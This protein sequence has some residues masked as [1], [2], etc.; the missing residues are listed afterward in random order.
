[1]I[2]DDKE[3]TIDVIVDA[4]LEEH[5]SPDAPYT[6]LISWQDRLMAPSIVDISQAVAEAKE[7]KERIDNI[8]LE[9]CFESGP[10]EAR[11][12]ILEACFESGPS[13][14]PTCG[15]GGSFAPNTGE[16]GEPRRG[17]TR[18]PPPSEARVLP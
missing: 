5:I 14:R 15:A 17:D 16:P 1:M 8:I 9:A 18:E 4:V 6:L 13:G 12:I 2:R 3:R 7:A 11:N 10:S